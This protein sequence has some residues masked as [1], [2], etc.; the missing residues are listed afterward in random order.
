MEKKIGLGTYGIYDVSTLKLCIK[1]AVLSGY[2][3]VDTAYVYENEEAI[4]QAL[5]ELKKEGFRADIKIQTKIWPEFYDDVA[6]A[7]KMALTKL[8][9]NKLDMC[10]LHRRHYDL[11][12]D[13]SAWQQLL[14]C[15]KKGLVEQIGVSNYDRDELEI[16]KHH[17][18]SYPYANQIE[19]SVNNIREDRITYCNSKKIAVQAWSPMGDLENNLKDLTLQK[20]AQK[21]QVDVPTILIAYLSSMGISV[22]VKSAHPQRVAKNKQAF[23]LLLSPA[24]IAVLKKL[25]SY[26]IKYSQTYCYDI[27]LND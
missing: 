26:K 3:F 13:I 10:L 24:D 9:L 19:L 16:M 22:V 25:N 27:H 15:Q 7:L 21:Y 2:D 6:K 11:N 1:Q 18:G 23:D 12:K 20:M 5:N 17:S 4:G 8:C 14:E